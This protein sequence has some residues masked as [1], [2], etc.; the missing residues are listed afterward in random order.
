MP[1]AGGLTLTNKSLLLLFDQKLVDSE[2]PFIIDLL[3][4]GPVKRNIMVANSA[5]QT[6]FYVYYL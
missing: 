2:L 5:V 3:H 4:Q 6:S 1:D